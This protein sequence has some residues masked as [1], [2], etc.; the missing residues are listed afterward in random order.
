VNEIFLDQT[1]LQPR[2]P[3]RLSPR[4]NF[5][6]RFLQEFKKLENLVSNLDKS[7][8]KAHF[9]QSVELSSLTIAVTSVNPQN[10]HSVSP[11]PTSSTSSVTSSPIT[12]VVIQPPPLIM[13][14]RYAPLVLVSPLHDMP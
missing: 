11:N 3:E 7:L 14:V 8:Y 4:T 9:Q 2:T 1:I 13:A 10:T 6:Q 12:Q 5:D